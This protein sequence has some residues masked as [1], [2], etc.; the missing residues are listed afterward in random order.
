MTSLGLIPPLQQDPPPEPLDRAET[1]S[2]DTTLN[3]EVAISVGAKLGTLGILL[4]IGRSI[5]TDDV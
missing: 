1:Q 3:S 5:S 4:P 2:P